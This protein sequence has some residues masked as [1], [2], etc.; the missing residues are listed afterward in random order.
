MTQYIDMTNTDGCFGIIAENGERI[1]FTGVTINAMPQSVKR[2]EGEAYD[3]FARLYDIYFI[4]DDKLPSVD[5]YTVPRTDIAAIDSDG[6]FIASVGE[7]FDLR[8]GGTLVY[9][10]KARSCYL[11]T[12]N[13]A[14]FLS[15]VTGWKGRLTPYD[16]IRIYDSKN[17]A[18]KD[19][20]IIDFDQTP[21]Y[22]NMM[23]LINKRK[24]RKG[25][26]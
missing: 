5:F 18:G 26:A 8:S 24:C 20:E 10:S 21:E 6:G 15:E 17:S 14:N 13:S 7:P 22:L 9:I 19:Y 3:E 16:G 12:E 11:I 25:Q 23:E 2:K 4:F 1:V